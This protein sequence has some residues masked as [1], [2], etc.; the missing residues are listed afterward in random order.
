[1]A[2]IYGLVIRF[3]SIFDVG[4]CCV[5]ILQEFIIFELVK[6]PFLNYHCDLIV[7]VDKTLFYHTSTWATDG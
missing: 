6:C 3:A 2:L 7:M 5:W 4:G 1:M